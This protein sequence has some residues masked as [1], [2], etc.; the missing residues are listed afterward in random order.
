MVV[1]AWRITDRIKDSIG[2]LGIIKTS[3][4][5]I[6]AFRTMEKNPHCRIP[7]SDAVKETRLAASCLEDMYHDEKRQA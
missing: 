5:P 7:D 4:V 1:L 3:L 2:S 6:A